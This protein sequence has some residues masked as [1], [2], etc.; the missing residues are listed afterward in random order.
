MKVPSS[1]D[2]FVSQM[3]G[4]TCVMATFPGSHGP[5]SGID[6]GMYTV[7]PGGVLSGTRTR[8]VTCTRCGVVV[9]HTPLAGV[10]ASGRLRLKGG[11]GHRHD[12]VLSSRDRS[13][14]L[15]RRRDRHDVAVFGV[16]RCDKRGDP[17]I[18]LHVTPQ[19]REISLRGGTEP[20]GLA[21]AAL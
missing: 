15:D 19:C 1:S 12:E 18:R 2:S 8:H 17:Q 21:A 10:G 3:P 13:G 5:S 20:H 9:W 16:G 6:P 11:R 4:S 14:V 7:S